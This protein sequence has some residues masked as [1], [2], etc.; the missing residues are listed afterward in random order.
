MRTSESP[1][2]RHLLLLLLVLTGCVLTTAEVASASSWLET[3]APGSNAESHAQAQPSAPTGLSASC[4]SATA[5]TIKV[6]WGAVTHA[7][8]YSVYKSTTSSTTGYSLAASGVTGTSWTSAT[9]SNATYWFQ[10]AVVVGTNWVS[11]NSAA[12]ASRTISS[13]GCS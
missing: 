4:T 10:V 13:S 8:S 11:P 2:H 7:T 3:L 12:P 5:K 6:T 9:L 1:R